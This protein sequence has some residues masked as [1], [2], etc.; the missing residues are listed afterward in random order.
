MSEVKD[1]PARGRFEMV[2]A[3]QIVFADYRR[4]GAR[5]IIDH[6]E[7]PVAL[8]GTGAAGRFM[9]GLV[10][11]ARRQGVK[12]VPLCSYAALWLQRRPE[13]SQDVVA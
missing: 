6:V 13:L 10:E 11:E 5:L 12:L 1:I 8:R 9:E 3:G 4:H 2:E 7:A